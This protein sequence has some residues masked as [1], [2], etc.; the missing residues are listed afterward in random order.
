[1][2]W[3]HGLQAVLFLV[4]AFEIARRVRV[5]LFEAALDGRTFCAA[6]A[7][8]LQA[9]QLALAARLAR[10]CAPAW[11]ARLAS[12]AIEAL[13]GDSSLADAREQIDRTRFELEQDSA[14]GLAAIATFGR[15]A[16]PLAFIGII[17]ELGRAFGGGHGLL[18]LKHGAAAQLALER[19]VLSFALG[20]GTAIVCV[21]AAV[22]LRRRARELREDLAQVARTIELAHG[23][24]AEM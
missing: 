17:V 8:A 5:L 4:A 7:P 2:Y 14:E 11:P 22:L 10:A 3:F 20:L 15:I 23:A 13:C 6:L 12:V 21:A 1:M 9:G 19:S 18:A 16:P 24:G